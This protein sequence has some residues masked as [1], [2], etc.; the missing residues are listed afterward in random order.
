MTVNLRAAPCGEVV[1]YFASWKWYQR[2]K[3]VRPAHIDF[4]K[5]TII[6]YAFFKP[7]A[8][9]SVTEGDGYA[10]PILLLGP[11]ITVDGARIRDTSQSLVHLAH[12]HGLKVIGSV[13]G[14]TWSPAFSQ[15][16]ADPSRRRR[17]AERCL[18]LV[19]KYDLDGI[20]IDWEHP[21]KNKKNEKEHFTSLLQQLRETFSGARTSSGAKIMITIA[22]GPAPAHL[23]AIDWERV[24]PM[25]D[26]VHLMAY[27]Y[28]GAW[29]PRTGHLA[30]L[31]APAYG[32]KRLCADGA[33]RMITGRFQVPSDKLTLGIPF[34]GRS[35][36]SIGKATLQSP[37]TGLPDAGTFPEGKGTPP[38]YAITRIAGSLDTEF[39][40]LS[41][42]TYL[43]GKN[44]RPLFISF[45]DTASVGLKATYAVEQ[46]LA[47]VMIWDLA[48]DYTESAPGS[49]RI[50][51]TPLVNAIHAALCRARLLASGTMG[52]PP[53]D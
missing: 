47:G 35:V 5:Y 9:G 37:S 8:D 45:D 31:Y 29:E 46:Q 24:T 15:L 28:S 7:Q 19:R 51:D 38:Y 1:A 2:G 14:W 12:R 13:G 4:S 30:P 11:E 40:P 43:T 49:G 25:V 21:G 41:R 23:E 39:D 50:K 33:V 16:S 53:G 36:L 32:D 48:G 20:D 3:L 22:V 18:H 10:D 34:F 6:N 27:N 17:F 52:I 44:D 42:A 26:L